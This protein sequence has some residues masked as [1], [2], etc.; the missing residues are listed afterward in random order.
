MKYKYHKNQ[1][2]EGRKIL[3][4]VLKEQDSVDIFHQLQK[5]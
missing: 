2:K 3:N 1:K 5:D 4:S